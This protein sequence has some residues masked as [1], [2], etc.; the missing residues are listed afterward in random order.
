MNILRNAKP[1]AV[2]LALGLIVAGCGAGLYAQYPIVTFASPGQ[3]LITFD[4]PILKDAK[5]VRVHDREA[6]E[7]VEYA[8]FETKTLMLEAVYDIALNNS[9]VLEYD[10]TMKRMVDTWNA[11]KGQAKTWGTQNSVWAWHGKVQYLPYRLSRFGLECAGF[12]SEWNFQP[13]DPFGRPG[14]VFF[15]YVCGKSGATLRQAEITKL[16]ENVKISRQDGS[17]FV[18]VGS[19]RS[20]NQAAFDTAKGSSGT[21]LGNSAFPFNFGRVYTEGEGR[22]SP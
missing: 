13:Q 7:F 14:K 9:I 6:L 3:A 12:S 5:V 1:S 17:S 20:I 8:R 18:P 11:N 2:F 22:R 15:G 19:R 10:Y 21:A 4:D 16:L